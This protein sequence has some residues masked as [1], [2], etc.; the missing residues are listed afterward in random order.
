MNSI[1][2]TKIPKGTHNPY[3]NEVFFFNLNLSESELCDEIILFEIY[4]SRTFRSNMKI[5]RFKIDIGYIYSQIKHSIQR[6][7]LLLSNEDDRMT[8]AKGYLKVSVNI[9]GS[10]DEPPVS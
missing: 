9:L 8:G 10:G 3:F 1:K 2:Q 7:W 5:G 6:K 4:N